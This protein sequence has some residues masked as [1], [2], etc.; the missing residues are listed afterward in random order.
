[1]GVGDGDPDSGKGSKVVSRTR[2][3]F[4]SSEDGIP[5]AMQVHLRMLVSNLLS[6]QLLDFRKHWV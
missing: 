6:I 1:M 2:G 5:G 4:L 3:G